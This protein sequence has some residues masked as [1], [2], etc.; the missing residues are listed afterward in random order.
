MLADSVVKGLILQTYGTGNAPNTSKAFI[1]VLQQAIERGIAVLNITQ[2]PYGSVDQRAYA[3]GETF[4][5]IGV[6]PGSDLTLE[7]AYAKMHF[8]LACGMSGVE[9]REKFS[10]SICGECG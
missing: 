6:I 2:C 3:T 8:L 4:N 10:Q 5:R 1:N 9:L 7:A